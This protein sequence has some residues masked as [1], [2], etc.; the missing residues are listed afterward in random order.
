MRDQPER[1]IAVSNE[2]VPAKFRKLIP[3]RCHYCSRQFFSDQHTGRPRL[4]CDKKC[5]DGEFRRSRYLTSQ[6]GESV[7]KNEDNSKPCK[8]I[9][10]DRPL[11]LNILGGYR[12]LT[13]PR[14]TDKC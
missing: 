3:G 14:S 5:R 13:A 2:L 9:F 7:S 12:C 4:F 6:N 10:G 8:G 11:P 1:M